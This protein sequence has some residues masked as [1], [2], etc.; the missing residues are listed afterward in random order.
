MHKFKTPLSDGGKF[1]GGKFLMKMVFFLN[2][3][4]YFGLFHKAFGP[5]TTKVLLGP[6]GPTANGNGAHGWIPE[7][8]GSE[9]TP[10][11]LQLYPSSHH[12]GI[13]MGPNNSSNLS[14]TA[15]F[16]FYD[17]EKE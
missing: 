5:C 2:L 11:I 1:A 8:G 12:Y 13:E 9:F 15:I 6:Q 4:I 10:I 3:W 17:H 14:N 7:V 16:H